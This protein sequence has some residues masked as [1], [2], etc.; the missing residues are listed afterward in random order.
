MRRIPAISGSLRPTKNRSLTTSACSGEAACNSASASFNR[1]RISSLAGAAIS[2]SSPGWVTVSKCIPSPPVRPLA[3]MQSLVRIVSF[4]KIRFMNSYQNAKTNGAFLP[5]P[6]SLVLLAILAGATAIQR[7]EA[8]TNVVVWDAGSRLADAP[9]AEN[10]A[11]WKSVSSEL[12]TFEADPPKAASDP[13]Y[14]G[15][16]Y[17]FK[18]NA[19]VE[20]HSLTAV[21]Y[22]TKGRVIL[23]SKADVTLPSGVWPGTAS[24]GQKILEFAPRQTGP[25]PSK[26][27]RCEILRNAGDEVTLNVSFSPGGSMDASAMFSFGKDAVVEIKPSEQMKGISL[28]SPIDYG[29]VPG[30]V[31]DDLVFGPTAYPSS[32]MLCLPVENMFVG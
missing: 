9:D 17:S 11:G 18:G 16:E 10:R 21:F 4:S 22:S 8:A 7:T 24:L 31:G 6:Q 27:S 29:I 2:I 28:F 30:F 23:Y 5:Q 12:F 3:S 25:Q 26:I 1:T 32:D 20:N 15:R 14:Y 13:G 19:V